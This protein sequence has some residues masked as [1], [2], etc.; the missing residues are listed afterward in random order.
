MVWLVEVFMVKFNLL[1][2][3]IIIGV[4]LFEMLSLI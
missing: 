4:E 1:D 2:D 3:I